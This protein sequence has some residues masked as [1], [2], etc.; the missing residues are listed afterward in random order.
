MS[1]YSIYIQVYKLIMKSYETGPTAYCPYLRRLESLTIC[2]RKAA[3]SA[4]LVEDPESWS[5]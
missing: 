3:L 1:V 5:R 4:Q 2:T